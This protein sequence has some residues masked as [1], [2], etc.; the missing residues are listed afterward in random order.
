M[1]VPDLLF[2]EDLHK[3]DA[4]L[5]QTPCHKTAPAV[6]GGS[7]VVQAVHLLSGLVFLGKIE[8]VAGGQL[9]PSRHLV[10]GDAGAQFRLIGTLRFVASIQ[11]AQQ[12]PF[13]LDQTAGQRL[14]GL[15]V[16]YR[17][18][19]GAETGALID[20]RQPGRLPIL[21]PISGQTQRIVEH[22]VTR[23][24]LVLT[25]QPV[26]DPGTLRGTVGQGAARVA[27][28]RWPVRG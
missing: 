4:S 15:Q 14:T 21:R 10:T 20:R 11:A 28:D 2:D 17:G 16:Q 9:H 19:F 18:S 13:G 26:G 1:G 25:A 22:H 8:G 27:S 23:K 7:I 6:R 3:A 24:V 5:H 12:G